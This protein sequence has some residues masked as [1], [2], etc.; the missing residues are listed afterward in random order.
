MRERRRI[1]NTSLAACSLPSPSPRG[2]LRGAD[3]GRYRA[4]AALGILAVLAR[5]SGHQSS[6]SSAV[7][8][9]IFDASAGP[10]ATTVNDPLGRVTG[11]AHLVVGSP[12]SSRAESSSKCS[13]SLPLTQTFRW[14]EA[15]PRPT[16]LGLLHECRSSPRCWRGRPVPQSSFAH[17]EAVVDHEHKFARLAWS[18][19]SR[20]RGRP[21]VKPTAQAHA[22]MSRAHGMELSPPHRSWRRPSS[23]HQ[24]H[25]PNDRIDLRSDTVTAHASHARGDGQ[26]P[27]G[28]R[29]LR[30]RPHRAR[31]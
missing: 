21:P 19:T 27:S 23:L 31:T 7:R 22:T 29:R 11:I 8:R 28:G 24:R 20:W 4:R 12:A 6:F 1:V 3:R 26:R 10:M 9:S 25:W 18:R 17:L 14:P 2:Q 13:A 15:N 16:V 5:L 30:R